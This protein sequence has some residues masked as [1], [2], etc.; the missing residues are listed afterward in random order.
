MLRLFTVNGSQTVSA[1]LETNHRIDP[2]LGQS[3]RQPSPKFSNKPQFMAKTCQNMAKIG[4]KKGGQVD[5]N[6]I[7]ARLRKNAAVQQ[8]SCAPQNARLS[9][10]LARQMAR[11]RR[12]CHFNDSATLN[13]LP[14]PSLK[15][16]VSKIGISHIP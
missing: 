4:R 16:Q 6:P 9:S 14:L 7:R 5:P 12:P 3:I 13:C 2:G 15:S 8:D 1:R 11:A 10:R